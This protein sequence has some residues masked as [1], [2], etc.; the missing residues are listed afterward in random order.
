[1][2]NVGGT[3]ECD[4]DVSLDTLTESDVIKLHC[5]V[6]YDNYPVYIHFNCSTE[7]QTMV[8]SGHI[9]RNVSTNKLTAVTT[10]Y[11]SQQVR[12]NRRLNGGRVMC[13][14]QFISM[15]RY[16]NVIYTSNWKSPSMTVACTPYLLTYFTHLICGLLSKVTSRGP[17]LKRI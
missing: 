16:H 13:T 3:L 4:S 17:Q 11:Y 2:C 14:V 8:E 7:P 1:M 6:S 12:V 9:H 15:D 5:H 10:T